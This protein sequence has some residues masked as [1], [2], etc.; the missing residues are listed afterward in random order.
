MA[1]A[2]KA[3]FLILCELLNESIGF[4]L[5][6]PTGAFIYKAKRL[7]TLSNL[8]LLTAGFL[9]SLRKTPE[10]FLHLLEKDA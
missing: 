6:R 5:E 10:G 7:N 2:R 9:F 4:N 1:A 8:K 3:R